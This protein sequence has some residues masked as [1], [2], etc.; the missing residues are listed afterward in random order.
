VGETD[1]LWGEPAATRSRALNDRLHDLQSD[2]QAVVRET[3]R[4]PLEDFRHAAEMF[5][6]ELRREYLRHH[7]RL[8][9]QARSG[10]E[11]QALAT[12]LRTQQAELAERWRGIVL[13][14]AVRLRRI[15]W[16][17]DALVETID[18]VVE[19]LPATLR[20]PW[21]PESLHGPSEG[22]PTRTLRRL[23]LR[24]RRAVRGFFGLPMPLRTLELRTLARYHLSGLAPERLEGLAALL[25]H[26][27]RHLAARTR[28]LFDVIVEGYDSLAR[29]VVSDTP[30]DA[31]D[32][33]VRMRREVE[34]EL[35]LA[36]D[37]IARMVRDGEQRTA[38]AFGDGLRAVKA[39]APRFGTFD[40][41]ASQR[42]SSRLFR[43]RMRAIETLTTRLER[44]R[45][46]GASGYAL[47]AMELELVGLVAQVKDA[48][49][50]HV[51]SLEK[52]V[53]G[54]AHT[55]TE[56]VE[57]ALRE[58]LQRV[59]EVLE[60]ERTGDDV[61]TEL[62]RMAEATERVAGEASRAATE[63]RDQLADERTGGA[64]LDALGRATRDLTE[65]YEVAGGRVARGEWKLPAAVDPVQVPFRELVQTWVDTRIAPRVMT[66]TREMASRV[67][68]LATSLGELERLVAFNVELATGEL[69]VVHD[70]AVPPETRTLL[71][72]MVSGTLERS[73]GMVHGYV[74]T[75]AGWADELGRDLRDAVLGASRRCA[76]RSWTRP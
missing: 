61:A 37:E 71:N 30:V 58:S 29:R 44:V 23:L 40:L 39:E 67:Q 57:G 47:L 46:T 27:D 63:L 36:L 73:M 25:V 19:G 18:R 12:Q 14:R 34:E 38:K 28:S 76:P 11:P 16:T 7:R 65:R 2:L 56:R 24:A 49:E 43:Q 3:A 8:A 74:E 10:D 26:A 31:A 20:V 41:P 45:R 60:D 70:E 6:R 54:R 21:E 50:L 5:L 4:G 22:A 17:P 32:A 51:S 68:P 62:R 75:S 15:G 59:D 35:A 72:E 48:L 52:A 64:L 66:C 53:R 42:R 13:G 69:E 33:L 55:Q 9:V 1:S